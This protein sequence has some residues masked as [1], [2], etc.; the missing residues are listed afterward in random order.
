[1]KKIIDA[2]GTIT[3]LEQKFIQGDT[4]KFDDEKVNLS[5]DYELTQGLTDHL[6][7]SIK[8]DTAFLFGSWGGKIRVEVPSVT[9]FEAHVSGISWKIGSNHEAR[10]RLIGSDYLKIH[11]GASTYRDTISDFKRAMFGLVSYVNLG[12]STNSSG[13]AIHGYPFTLEPDLG[14]I[15]L[16][17]GKTRSTSTVQISSSDVQMTIVP[18]DDEWSSFVDDT[19]RRHVYVAGIQKRNGGNLSTSEVERYRDLLTEFLSW[20]N[21]C[22]TLIFLTRYFCDD[23]EVFVE[24]PTKCH[25][26]ERGKYRSFYPE[27]IVN[28]PKPRTS[29]VQQLWEGFVPLYEEGEHKDSFKSVL[30][31]LHKF[32]SEEYGGISSFFS[33]ENGSRWGSR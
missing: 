22:R 1:M 31:M 21:G 24:V 11:S 8:S 32:T 33:L 3:L 23:K 18:G 27:V 12:N 15:Q 16:D 26:S 30:D 14:S 10:I 29:V 5:V 20:I 25:L 4:R 19:I 13:L 7:M 17:D 28:D 2:E 9:E 6:S